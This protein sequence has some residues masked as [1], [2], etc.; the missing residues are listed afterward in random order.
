MSCSNDI[1][2]VS[3]A[4]NSARKQGSVFMHKDDRSS[5]ERSSRDIEPGKQLITLSLPSRSQSRFRIIYNRVQT[6]FSAENLGGVRLT[7]REARVQYTATGVDVK[8]SR[9]INTPPLIMFNFTFKNKTLQRNRGH[10]APLPALNSGEIVRSS[11]QLAPHVLHVPRLLLKYKINS[12]SSC[13]RRRI[14][15]IK[16]PISIPTTTWKAEESHI[17]A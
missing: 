17:C 14:I 6:Y 13:E 2:I 5:Q 9:N 8:L 7:V 12:F 16:Q 15:R 10:R 11:G 4:G 1:F 3:Q